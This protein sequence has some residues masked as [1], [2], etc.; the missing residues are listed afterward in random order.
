MIKMVWLAAGVA[1]SVVGAVLVIFLCRWR[2]I[3]TILQPMVNKGRLPEEISQT[4]LTKGSKKTPRTLL[5]QSL[6]ALTGKNTVMAP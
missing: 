3:R 4:L 6:F 2:T 1:Q 5:S